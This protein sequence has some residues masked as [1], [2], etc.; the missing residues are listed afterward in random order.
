[1]GAPVGNTNNQD[2]R[3][4]RAA[5]RRALDKR[6]LAEK[7][8]ELEKIAEALLDKALAGDV[9]ALRELGDRLEGKANQPIT[10]ADGAP[11]VVQI[12]AADDEL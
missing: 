5:I 6:S 10:G 3:L 7:R 12:Q 8:D 11:F 1:M 4:W 9:G 2:G